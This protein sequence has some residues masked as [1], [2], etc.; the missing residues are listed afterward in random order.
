MRSYW[1]NASLSQRA[2][3]LERTIDHEI[4]TFRLINREG[5]EKA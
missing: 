3:S 5:R 1:R 2:H 4:K